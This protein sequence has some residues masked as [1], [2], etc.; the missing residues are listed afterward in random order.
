[1]AG[2][3]FWFYARELCNMAFGMAG[4]NMALIVDARKIGRWCCKIAFQFSWPWLVLLSHT[5]RYPR[6]IFYGM[7]TFEDQ[8]ISGERSWSAPQ[9]A[10]VMFVQFGE[11]PQDSI[12]HWTVFWFKTR[13]CAEENSHFRR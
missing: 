7:V 6:Y 4:D 8:L 13:E 9:C 1:M 3:S 11:M 5:D 2:A 12:T 10:F